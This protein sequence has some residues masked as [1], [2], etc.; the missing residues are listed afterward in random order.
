MGPAPGHT[1]RERDVPGHED[2]FHVASLFGLKLAFFLG[3]VLDLHSER[4][5]FYNIG[6]SRPLLCYF[7]LF[8]TFLN[9]VYSK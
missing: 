9:K 6:H 3:H 2:G 4:V 1:G 5:V 7:R 8:N